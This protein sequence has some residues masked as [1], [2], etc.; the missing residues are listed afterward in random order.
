MKVC[1]LAVLLVFA[2]G[3]GESQAHLFAALPIDSGIGEGSVVYVAH[4]QAGAVA[5]SRRSQDRK[6]TVARIELPP[7][8]LK[9]LDPG[10]LW[11][12]RPLKLGEPKQILLASNLCLQGAPKGVADGAEVQVLSGPMHYLLSVMNRD[13]ETCMT[14]LG[15][16]SFTRFRAEMEAPLG[17]S[18]KLQKR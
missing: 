10:T 1:E 13:H 14:R 15:K 17:V 4:Q 2:T 9:L 8:T 18:E 3:C 7:A 6:S 11:V 16:E 5:S 12:V